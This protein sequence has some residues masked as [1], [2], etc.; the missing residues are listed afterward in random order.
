MT[1][2]DWNTT[3]AA[4]V[5]GSWNLHVS[6]PK[7]LEFFVLLAS[8]SGIV[9]NLGQAN[10][11]AGDVYQDQLAH[12][13]RMQ[14][15]AATSVDLGAVMGVGYLA[16]NTDHYRGQEHLEVIQ[17]REQEI[18]TILNAIITGHSKDQREA[19]P[20]I[21]TGI[22]S[23]E[24]LR[25]FLEKFEW[26]SDPKLSL[27]RRINGTKES[28]KEVDITRTALMNTETAAEAAC[29]IED[30]LV[31]RL[32]KALAISAEDINV[33]QPMHSYGGL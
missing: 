24:P 14:G 12:Y 15:L 27:L 6:L 22:P 21:T 20:Q 17:V 30:A 13:R 4:K 18:Y 2:E 1:Y 26:A 29:V 5:Q 7:D 16:E 28:L 9:G 32:A 23:G 19:S 25:T 31:T 33:A 8:A 3:T 10:Y 11:A